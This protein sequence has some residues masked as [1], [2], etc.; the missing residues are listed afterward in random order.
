[1]SCINQELP[2]KYIASWSGGKD[3]T[4]LVDELLRRGEP[5]DEVI[6]CDTGFEFPEMYE[7]IAKCK[8]YW[9]GKYPDIKITL[10]NWGD[11]AKEVYSS[12][13][14]EPFK[15]GQYKGQVRGFPFHMGMSWCTREL[16]VN[17]ADNYLKK[18][19]PADKY[20]VMKYIGIAVDEPKRIPEN[21]GNQLYPMA[22]WGITEAQ[23]E[24]ILKSRGLH[25][26][27]YNHFD[28]TGCWHCPKQSLKSLNTL[29]KYHPKLWQKLKEMEQNYKELG[30][31]V[32][33][34][35]GIGVEAIEVKLDNKEYKTKEGEEPIGC[36]CK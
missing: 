16:K 11:K 33:T 20:Q 30:A 29:R 4:Y 22:T 7:Y 35:K 10:L 9:E 31:G 18:N 1:M 25:N 23:A 3:S 8:A 26:P 14:D 34:F 6:F 15:K 36:F 13:A 2:K 12:W 28:R 17:P 5:L 27:L 19:Y 24:Q 21:W 32:D